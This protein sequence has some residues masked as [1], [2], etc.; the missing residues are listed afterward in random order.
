MER[1][2][3]QLVL[4]ERSG[5]VAIIT[6]DRP[7]RHNSLV[8]PLL[9]ALFS[10]LETAQIVAGRLN[11]SLTTDPVW[12]E[13]DNGNLAGSLRNALPPAPPENIYERIG[14]DGESES[15]LFL[16]AGAAL[17]SILFIN[18]D[19]PR[20]ARITCGLLWRR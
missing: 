9:E 16:R 11:R 15:E 4:W 13:R 17:H 14:S 5:P 10:A 20:N 2:V 19:R 3:S 7:E 12:K 1:G 18:L 6:L 8:P